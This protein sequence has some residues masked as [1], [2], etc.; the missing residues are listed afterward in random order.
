MN[1]EFGNFIIS[2]MLGI[3]PPAG[4]KRITDE[5]IRGSFPDLFARSRLAQIEE[6]LKS[7][8]VV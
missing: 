7:R 5:K 1:A 2:T 6:R 8:E 3:E 4:V